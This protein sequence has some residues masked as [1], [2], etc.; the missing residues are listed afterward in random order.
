MEGFRTTILS[1]PLQFSLKNE[2]T[3]KSLLKILLTKQPLIIRTN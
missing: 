1:E 3:M 2:C